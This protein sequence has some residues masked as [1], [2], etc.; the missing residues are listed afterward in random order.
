[1]AELKKELG[2][3][4]PEEQ[5]HLVQQTFDRVAEFTKMSEVHS[6]DWMISVNDLIFDDGPVIV[7]SFGEIRRATW[8]HDGASQKVVVKQILNEIAGDARGAFTR[9]LDTW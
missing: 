5:L 6:S 2:K 4:L 7:G 3:K 8:Y 1:M 9:Q